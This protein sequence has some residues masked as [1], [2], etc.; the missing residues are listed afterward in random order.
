MGG[1]VGRGCPGHRAV[2][3]HGELG[4][5]AGRALTIVPQHLRG[6]DWGA[7]GLRVAAGG[8]PGSELRWAGQVLH[9]VSEATCHCHRVFGAREGVDT[10]C[11]HG[12]DPRKNCLVLWT[13]LM[14]HFLRGSVAG[15]PAYLP[16]AQVPGSSDSDVSVDIY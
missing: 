15:L 10:S 12:T 3:A 2:G 9:T 8:L 4:G 13:V 6:T 16:Q 1:E 7:G 11:Y 5:R 14:V